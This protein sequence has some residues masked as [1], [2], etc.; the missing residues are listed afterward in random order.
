MKKVLTLKCSTVWIG[1]LLLGTP[2]MGAT[3]K[4]SSFLV[5]CWS[6]KTG[7]EE[8]VE[9]WNRPVGSAMLGNSQTVKDGRNTF[10]EFLKITAIENTLYYTPYVNGIERAPF[11]LTAAGNTSVQFENPKDAHLHVIRYTK[12][13]KGLLVNLEF[14]GDDGKPEPVAYVLTEVRCP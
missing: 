7:S 3:L 8:T 5:G 10:F 4:D 6:N 2:L 14:V 11:K 13:T 12:Q 9:R 1:L